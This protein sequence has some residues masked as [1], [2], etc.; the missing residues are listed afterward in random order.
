MSVLDEIK[1]IESGLREQRC[2][3]EVVSAAEEVTEF[4]PDRSD[5]LEYVSAYREAYRGEDVDDPVGFAES[6]YESFDGDMSGITDQFLY[7]D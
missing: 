4:F 2:P 7:E 1:E 5:A 3:D 6:W